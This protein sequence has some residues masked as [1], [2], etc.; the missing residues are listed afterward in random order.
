MPLPSGL[1]QFARDGSTHMPAPDPMEFKTWRTGLL[2]K[3]AKKNIPTKEL[4]DGTILA[5]FG[6]AIRDLSPTAQAENYDAYLTKF[7]AKAR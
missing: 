2:V 6:T 1:I 3:L 4:P 7:F 5:K